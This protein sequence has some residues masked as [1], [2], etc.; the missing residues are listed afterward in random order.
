MELYS[1]TQKKYILWSFTKLIAQGTHGK[2]CT[3]KQRGKQN[4]FLRRQ[5]PPVNTKN[6]C[7]NQLVSQNVVA[8]VAYEPEKR[9]SVPSK[10][11][12]HRLSGRFVTI[13][14]QLLLLD[15]F[16]H[17]YPPE[18]VL[19]LDALLRTLTLL[20]LLPHRHVSTPLPRNFTFTSY[21]SP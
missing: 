21:F 3:W 2:N 4:N 17:D 12:L 16:V 9:I 7:I 8:W 14:R 18:W 5:Y 13:L 15:A 19:L 20:S 1:A 6:Q 10:C 11:T